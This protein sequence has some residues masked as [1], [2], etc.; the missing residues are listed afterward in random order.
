MEFSGG[1]GVSAESAARFCSTTSTK[2]RRMNIG[3]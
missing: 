3:V 2:G 1:L